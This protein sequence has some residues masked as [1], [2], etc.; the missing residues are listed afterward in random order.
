MGWH[1]ET[2]IGTMKFNEVCSNIVDVYILKTCT[3]L[4][5]RSNSNDCLQSTDIIGPSEQN[6][7]IFEKNQQPIELAFDTWKV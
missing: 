7:I 6:E 3:H 1:T 5:Y 4:N 2:D